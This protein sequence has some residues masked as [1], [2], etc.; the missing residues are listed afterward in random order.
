M[1]SMVSKLI[2][3]VF[4]IMLIGGVANVFAVKLPSDPGYNQ[5][6]LTSPDIATKA[7]N[8]MNVFVYIVNVLAIATMIFMGLRYM[9]ASSEVK[10]DIKK[11]TVTWVI[12][13]II[14]FAATTLVGLVLNVV[15]G[16]K[17]YVTVDPVEEVDEEDVENERVSEWANEYWQKAKSAGFLP[18]SIKNK[19]TDKISRIE[20]SEAIFLLAKKMGLTMN[21][22]DDTVE[23]SDISVPH[24]ED[25]V[26]KLYY[27]DIITGKGKDNN[28]NITF[29]P[30]SNI[31]REDV[32]V[33]IYRLLQKTQRTNNI[34]ITDVDRQNELYS[35]VSNYAKD[36]MI[37]MNKDGKI[38]GDET[39]DLNPK[40]YTTCEQ[41]I[42]ILYRVY[43]GEE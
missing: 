31:T 29:D 12:G 33:I 39:G 18:D 6:D 37:Y 23:V 22:P 36:A 3:F 20:F 9:F 13:A 25:I 27:V 4:I 5:N 32:A 14:V 17:E 19:P 21:L 10:A 35:D 28:G 43:S 8:V 16:D 26:L 30:F 42:T 1:K 34:A 24:L 2:I 38:I 11:N 41:A 15:V 7:N 40:G